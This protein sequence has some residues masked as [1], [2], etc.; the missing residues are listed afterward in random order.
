M[1][2]RYLVE[3]T[4]FISAWTQSPQL[5]RRKNTAKIM[6]GLAFVFLIS[7]LPYHALWTH[8]ITTEKQDTSELK[9]IQIVP[10]KNYKLGKL[11]SISSND[12]KI[13][14]SYLIST[15]L[16]LLNSCLN[17]VA[18]FGMSFTFR[19]KLKAFITYCKRNSSPIDLELRR[20]R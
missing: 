5:Q 9:V 10:Q 17:P 8:I 16:L 11:M 18:Q 12:Y 3:S 4:V 13:E 19:S 20:R 7:Y 14:Y 15:C 6:V 2:A 1:T